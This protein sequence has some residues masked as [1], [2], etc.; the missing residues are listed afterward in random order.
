MKLY[1]VEWIRTWEKAEDLVGC[2][3]LIE[4]FNDM[5]KTDLN[6]CMVTKVSLL[7]HYMGNHSAFSIS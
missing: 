4:I 5:P 1:Q 7:L 2:E 6:G 3:D